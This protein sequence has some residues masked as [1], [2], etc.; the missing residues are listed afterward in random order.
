M[1]KELLQ[2]ISGLCCFA[3]EDKECI[4]LQ[5]YLLLESYTSARIYLDK[6]ID[7]IEWCLAFDEND[8][9][10]K[11]QLVD[12][13]SLMDLVIELTIINEGENEREQVRT[14]TQ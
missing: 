10:I 5:T 3:L 8:E 4:K 13:N 2:K 12:T 9:T 14:I 6:L 1:K 7:N 11:Q